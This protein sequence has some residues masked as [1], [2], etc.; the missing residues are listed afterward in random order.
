[1]VLQTKDHQG[2]TEIPAPLQ[3]G[4]IQEKLTLDTRECCPADSGF[5]VSRSVGNYI[6]VAFHYTL[7]VDLLP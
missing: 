3:A 6:S 7:C 5:L 1:M 4:G 2:P